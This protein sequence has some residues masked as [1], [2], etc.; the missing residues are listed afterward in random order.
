MCSMFLMF[1]DQIFE[2]V[3][4]IC[5]T[6]TELWCAQEELGNPARLIQPGRG[7]QRIR[8]RY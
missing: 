2:D 1:T 6:F 5:N 4:T 7:P 8:R 3:K